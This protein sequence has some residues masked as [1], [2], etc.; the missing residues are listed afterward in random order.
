[1]PTWETVAAYVQACGEDP[2]S[3]RAR[4]EAVQEEEQARRLT[5]STVSGADADVSDAS[6]AEQTPAVA[7]PGA[8]HGRSLLRWEVV[9]AVF[10]MLMAAVVVAV[11]VWGNAGSSPLGGDSV[12]PAA[13][14]VVVVVQNKVALGANG[15]VE[16]TTPAYLSAKTLPRCGSRGC[17]LDGTD[18]WSGA[19]LTTVC[20]APGSMVHNYDL[21]DP[22]ALG[23]PEHLGSSL[24]YRLSMPDGRTG[25]LSEVYIAPRYRIGQGLPTCRG[26]DAE[27]VVVQ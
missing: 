27:G 2:R 8:V 18:F 12:S 23:N 10:A 4:W 26:L 24:W 16:D 9:G 14:P 7:A 22:A 19:V 11:L 25:W 17:K 15:L 6:A 3:W 13:E 1:L 20:I 5:G 21:T